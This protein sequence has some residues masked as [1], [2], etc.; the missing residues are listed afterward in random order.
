M[1][2]SEAR[3]VG[4]AVRAARIIVTYT[5][6]DRAHKL[7]EVPE[8]STEALCDARPQQLIAAQFGALKAFGRQ[9]RRQVAA[10]GLT[11]HGGDPS[12][13]RCARAMNAGSGSLL[14]KPLINRFQLKNRK[15]CGA[16][17]VLDATKEGICHNRRPRGESCN[18]ALRFFEANTA[19]LVADGRTG[20]LCG[21][22]RLQHPLTRA[23]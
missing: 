16:D 18:S 8:S 20:R 7:K 23:A 19:V 17:V 1:F 22:R 5:N 12:Y 21:D 15:L 2:L 13:A 14:R 4:I 10:R 11:P 9:N 6:R 3:G